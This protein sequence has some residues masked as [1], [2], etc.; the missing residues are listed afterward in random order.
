[1]PHKGDQDGRQDGR[2]ER[3]NFLGYRPGSDI[4]LAIVGPEVTEQQML[5]LTNKLDDLPLPYTFDLARLEAIRD[6]AL[7]EHI[8]RVGIVFYQLTKRTALKGA[9]K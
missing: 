8:K 6:A 1:M 3:S 2:Q 9:T 5:Q 7:I 4:D